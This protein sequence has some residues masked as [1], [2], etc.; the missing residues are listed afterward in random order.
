[1]KFLIILVILLSPLAAQGETFY[2]QGNGSFDVTSLWNTARDG[3][4]GGNKSEP[5]KG[6]FNNGSHRWVIQSGDTLTVDDRWRNITIVVEGYLKLLP[7]QR[8]EP[9]DSLIIENGGVM[10]YNFESVDLLNTTVVE[11]GGGS[12]INKDNVLP[13]E[14]TFFKAFK[15]KDKVNLKWETLSE[16]E[17]YGFDIYRNGA[18]IHFKMGLSFSTSPHIYY[19]IDLN[20]PEGTLTYYLV[21]KDFDG[22]TQ[23]Y[24]PQVVFNYKGAKVSVK[25]KKAL[26]TI[27]NKKEAQAVIY[28]LLGEKIAQFKVNK[29]YFTLS[30][31]LT[32]YAS[33]VYFLVLSHNGYV[34]TH[35]FHLF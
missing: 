27:E 10:D 22:K 21:Q 24:G 26:V 4:D 3:S 11:E 20:P 9:N 29:N 34:Q 6:D 28:N 7:G 25:S 19:Y 30:L 32:S 5:K 15:G 12:Q 31:N 35:K 14:L 17:N 33:G 13:V 8:F 23:R 2:S 18:V 16:K 1:M